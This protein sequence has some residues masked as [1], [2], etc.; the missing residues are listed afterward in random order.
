MLPHF[1]PL[2]W[3]LAVFSAFCIGFAKS[4]FSGA[5]LVNVIVMASLFGPRESTGVV[6]PM[7]ICGDILSVIAFHQHARW[8]IVWRMLPPTIIGIIA[9]YLLMFK[10]TDGRVFG[11]IIGWIILAMVVLQAIRRWYPKAFEKAPHTR[12]FAWSMGL[13]G[14]VTTMLANGAGPIMTLYFLATET[15][16]YALV[17]TGAWMFLILNSFKV[18]FSW[19]LGLIHGSSLLFNVLLVPAIVGGTF[20]GRYLIRFIQQDLFEALVLVFAATAALHMI[21]LF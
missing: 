6:L 15:P 16:K 2:Q 5:S 8:P 7:L 13:T 3:S 9:G 1:T 18:P 10:L 17:G 14:G 19:H 12:Q 21:R 20:T 4:G 11:P